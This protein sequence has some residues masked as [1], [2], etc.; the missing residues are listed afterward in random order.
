[1][2]YL[3]TEPQTLA[4]VATD[5]EELGSAITAANTAAASP[6]SG[7]A[8]AAADEVSDAIA[9]LFGAYGRQYQAVATRAAAFHT[10]FTDALAAAGSATKRPS[11]T[12]KCCSTVR[13]GR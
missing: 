9:K 7:L 10:N 2:T 1:M 3:L 6:I 5:I 11:Q 4:W 13:A 12:P 8:P